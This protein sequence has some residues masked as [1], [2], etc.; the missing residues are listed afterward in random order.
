MVRRCMKSKLPTIIPGNWQ[1]EILGPGSFQLGG[2]MNQSPFPHAIEFSFVTIP[3]LVRG[4]P[5]IGLPAVILFMAPAEPVAHAHPGSFMQN[6]LVIMIHLYTNRAL[7]SDL[8][9]RIEIGKLK[10]VNFKANE[11]DEGILPISMWGMS[12]VIPA[13]V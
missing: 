10:S 12:T 1:A 11:G 6:G 5:E 2:G 4:P 3:A 8:L 13:Q 7:F 9:A